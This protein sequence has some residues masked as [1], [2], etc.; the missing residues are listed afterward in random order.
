MFPTETRIILSSDS[1]RTEYMSGTTVITGT[2]FNKPFFGEA[3]YKVASLSG[4]LIGGNPLGELIPQPPLPPKPH[5]AIILSLSTNR[6]IQMTY[7]GA[8]ISGCPSGG[9]QLMN[10]AIS[11]GNAARIKTLTIDRRSGVV[12]VQ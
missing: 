3:L 2:A 7:S 10:T 9:C 5:E 4:T 1:I 12:E 8:G 11:L 6:D